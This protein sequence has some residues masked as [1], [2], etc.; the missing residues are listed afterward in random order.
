MSKFSFKK[1]FG[2]VKQKDV[3]NIKEE[4]MTALNLN[5]RE[6]WRLRLNGITEPKVSEAQEVERIFNEYGIT[7]IWG[8]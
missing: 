2:Q 4:I 6:A 3:L 5:S 8:E 7:E 1:G